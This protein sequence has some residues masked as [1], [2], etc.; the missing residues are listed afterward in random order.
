[1]EIFEETFANQELAQI[2]HVDNEEKQNWQ[3]R[4]HNE[5]KMPIPRLLNAKLIGS[6]QK[7][8]NWI[9]I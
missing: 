6:N 3:Q 2:Y 7:L 5:I 9:K 1:L 4:L 8:M